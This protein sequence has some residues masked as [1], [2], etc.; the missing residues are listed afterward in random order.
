MTA[1]APSG[2]T[3][4]MLSAMTIGAGIDAASRVATVVWHHA[5]TGAERQRARRPGI[6]EHA[7]DCATVADQEGASHG[8]GG[9]ARAK[10]TGRAADRRQVRRAPRAGLRLGGARRG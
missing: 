6:P 9:V 1:P 2:P 5:D 3:R 10:A 8:I 4:V 7:A